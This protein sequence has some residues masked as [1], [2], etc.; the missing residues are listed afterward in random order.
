M[1]H[2]FDTTGTSRD[3]QAALPLCTLNALTPCAFNNRHHV[4]MAA[5]RLQRHEYR[6]QWL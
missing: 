6:W 3:S 5:T 1:A 2:A 4:N